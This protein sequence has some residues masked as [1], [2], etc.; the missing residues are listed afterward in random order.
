[1]K[2]LFAIHIA[3]ISIYFYLIHS[4]RHRAKLIYR[5][6]QFH[7]V[8]EDFY[9]YSSNNLL[10]E[11][12]QKTNS[13]VK[14]S[15]KNEYNNNNK[16]KKKV[17]DQGYDGKYSID[18]FYDEKG[19]L[20]KESNSN[21]SSIIHTYSTIK[22]EFIEYPKNPLI[23]Y[24][25]SVTDEKGNVI[26]EYKSSNGKD[27]Y[28][29]VERNYFKNNVINSEKFYNLKNNSQTETYLLLQYL[30]NDSGSLLKVK[31]GNSEGKIINDF[32]WNYNCS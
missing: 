11:E 19:S 5:K 20:I 18:Y 28:L 15:V 30:Y 27:Y 4:I 2:Y 23:T 22:K 6:R 7:S 13:I 8:D 31:L 10:L 9:S 17:V 14:Y 16:I 21:G 26:E 24:H 32:T 12:T 3:N 1:M 25:H 29:L